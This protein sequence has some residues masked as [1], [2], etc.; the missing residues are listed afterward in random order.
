MGNK[1]KQLKEGTMRCTRIRVGRHDGK[2][3]RLDILRNDRGSCLKFKLEIVYE[4]MT[5]YGPRGSHT[6]IIVDSDNTIRSP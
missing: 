3:I 5:I 2:L 1:Q 4:R 6:T